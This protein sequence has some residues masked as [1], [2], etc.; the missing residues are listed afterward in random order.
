M[1][2]RI[3]CGGFSE[4]IEADT[5]LDAL[6]DFAVIYGEVSGPMHIEEVEE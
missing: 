3:R 2:Y 6:R 5:K 4:Y 1:K